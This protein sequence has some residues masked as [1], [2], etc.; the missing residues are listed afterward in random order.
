MKIDYEAMAKGNSVSILFNVFFYFRKLFLW[1][2]KYSCPYSRV[3]IVKSRNVGKKGKGGIWKRHKIVYLVPRS[4]IHL[5]FF[6]FVFPDF[7]VLWAKLLYERRPCFPSVTTNQRYFFFLIPFS[8][9]NFVCSS[10]S[11]LSLLRSYVQFVL[12]I[13]TDLFSD[14]LTVVH[15]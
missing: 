2:N 3:N 13:S 1:D 8:V 11:Y 9:S 15:N 7:F 14:Y 4:S 12:V 6:I 5:I 10:I